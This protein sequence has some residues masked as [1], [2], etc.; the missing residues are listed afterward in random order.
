MFATD[1]L[2]LFVLDVVVGCIFS[3]F[4]TMVVCHILIDI[5]LHHFDGIPA[6]LLLLAISALL[7]SQV[8]Y[9]IAFGNNTTKTNTN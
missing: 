3:V 8:Y 7:L 2:I 5:S 1:S 4:C 9:Q 6:G